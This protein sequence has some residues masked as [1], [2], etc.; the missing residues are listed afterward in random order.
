MAKK[1]RFVKR[2]ATQSEMYNQ[3]IIQRGTQA[4]SVSA[5][6]HLTHYEMEKI[7]G[8]RCNDYDPRCSSCNAW[9]NWDS[10]GKATLTF[11]R[12]ELVTLMLKGKI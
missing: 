6:V 1:V 7:F 2:K 3:M 5:E 9:L 10:T 4:T 12:N 8:P 11:G